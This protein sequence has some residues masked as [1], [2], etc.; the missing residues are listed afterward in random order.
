MPVI[1]ALRKP[2][3]GDW[4]MKANMIYTVRCCL[5]TER[6]GGIRP[7][8]EMSEIQIPGVPILIRRI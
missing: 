3:Q 6:E 4:E 5:K 2:K 1:Q 8:L 7:L